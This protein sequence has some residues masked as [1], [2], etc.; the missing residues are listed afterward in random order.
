MT[1]LWIFYA[2]LAAARS[3]RLLPTRGTRPLRFKLLPNSVAHPLI[4]QQYVEKS[5]GRGKLFLQGTDLHCKCFGLRL[6]SI[7][8]FV[9][10]DG[11]QVR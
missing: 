9:S 1:S 5:L 3:F 7:F 4:V 6:E 2:P 8:S 10:F 11:Q